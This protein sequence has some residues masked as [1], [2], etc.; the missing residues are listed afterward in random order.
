MVRLSLS[1]LIDKRFNRCVIMIWFSL[2]VLY[3]YLSLILIA[4]GPSNKNILH[5]FPR[6]TCYQS[7]FDMVSFSRPLSCLYEAHASDLERRVSVHRI[8]FFLHI[9]I[10]SMRVDLTKEYG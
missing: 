2:Y 10:R 9:Y 1:Y 3:I 5:G 4:Y 6:T 8:L 7:F